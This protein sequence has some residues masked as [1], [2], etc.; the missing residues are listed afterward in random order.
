LPNT[1]NEL[2]SDYQPKYDL[3][4][5]FGQCRLQTTLHRTSTTYS[6]VPKANMQS[7]I[8]LKT[9]LACDRVSENV[10]AWQ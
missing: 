1:V 6:L 2:Y 10:A 7:E 8:K 9:Q 3:K 5:Q 4:V